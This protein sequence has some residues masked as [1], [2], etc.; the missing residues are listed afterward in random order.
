VLEITKLLL[1]YTQV[2]KEIVRRDKYGDTPLRLFAQS[3]NLEIL[4]YLDDVKILELDD[5]EEDINGTSLL[6]LMIQY[7]YCNIV[8]GLHQ[9]NSNKIFFIFPPFFVFPSIFSFLS[10]FVFRRISFFYTPFGI[11]SGPSSPVI[12]ILLFSSNFS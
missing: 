4:K 3:G 5:L 9:K 12:S 11:F 7:S 10:L 2:N 1:Q 8:D 6:N